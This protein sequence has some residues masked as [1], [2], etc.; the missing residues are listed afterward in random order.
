[1]KLWY[2]KVAGVDSMLL[3]EGW[4]FCGNNSGNV[5]L[6]T[7]AVYDF[8][9]NI[10]LRKSMKDDFTLLSKKGRWL[11]TRVIPPGSTPDWA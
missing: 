7:K 2:I 3:E 4:Q 5:K 6:I 9:Q 11:V 8:F 10:K 1:M